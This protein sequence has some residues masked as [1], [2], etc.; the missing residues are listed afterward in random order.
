VAARL[1]RVI[2]SVEVLY[3]SG[4]PAGVLA[5]YG[6]EGAGERMLPKPFTTDELKRRLQIGLEK[7]ERRREER[8]LM[9]RRAG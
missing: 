1:S 9:A 4:Y 2:P 8:R 6:L 5:W 7:T 3:M